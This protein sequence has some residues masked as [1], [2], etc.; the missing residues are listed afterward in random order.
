[1]PYIEIA[2]RTKAD[3]MKLLL[4]YRA[5]FL[6]GKYTSIEMNSLKTSVLKSP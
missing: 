2:G 3:V 4:L 1:M 6:V 5:G